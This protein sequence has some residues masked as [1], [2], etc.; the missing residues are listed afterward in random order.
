MQTLV[1]KNKRAKISPGGIISLPVAARK[2]LGMAP[3]AGIC[4]TI[5]VTENSVELKPVKGEGGSRVS[6][7]GQLD[8]HGDARAKLQSGVERHIWMEVSDSQS[9]VRLHPWT[10]GQDA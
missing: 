7:K 1:F 5:A 4:V 6:P 9:T 2:A 3:G 10:S 8:L